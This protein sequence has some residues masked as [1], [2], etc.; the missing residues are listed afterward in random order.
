[1]Q[2]PLYSNDACKRLSDNHT[3]I[4]PCFTNLNLHS[5]SSKYIYKYIEKWKSHPN[6]IPFQSGICAQLKKKSSFYHY[7]IHSDVYG[8]GVRSHS[9]LF[10]YPCYYLSLWKPAQNAQGRHE[11]RKCNVSY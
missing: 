2:V 10:S 8:D 1:M 3:V 5:V 4:L 11:L 9:M 7:A 6:H